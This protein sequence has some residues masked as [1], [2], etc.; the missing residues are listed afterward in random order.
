MDDLIPYF[1]PEPFQLF[2]NIQYYIVCYV[3]IES[4]L[5]NQTGYIYFN[6]YLTVKHD[7]FCKIS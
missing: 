1:K 2:L 6:V 4:Y 5:N 3:F 7:K